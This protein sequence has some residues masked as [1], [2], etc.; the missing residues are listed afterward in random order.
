MSYQSIENNGVEVIINIDDNEHSPYK[1][2]I[3][4]SVT[5]FNTYEELLNIAQT[6]LAMDRYL[7]GDKNNSAHYMGSLIGENKA[8][9]EIIE[10]LI[11]CEQ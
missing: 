8:Y 11:Q 5:G 9:K 3:F 10:R 6:I 7:H 4:G 2:S 1:L